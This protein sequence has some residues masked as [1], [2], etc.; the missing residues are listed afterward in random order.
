MSIDLVRYREEFGSLQFGAPETGILELVIANK[1]RL[2]AA[3]ESMHRD[4]AT[5]WRSID[6]D[7]AVRA[8][9]ET[10][11]GLAAICGALASAFRLAAKRYWGGGAAAAVAALSRRRADRCASSWCAA[12]VRISRRAAIST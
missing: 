10:E 3:T 1:G 2:N 8:R 5:V 7:D 9:G 11:N 6:L 4:L 12:R